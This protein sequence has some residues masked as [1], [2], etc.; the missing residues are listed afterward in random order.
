MFPRR[1][2]G[3]LYPAGVAGFDVQTTAYGR[4]AVDLLGRQ[5]RA[6]KR[7]DPLAPVT[8][9]VPSNYAAVSTRRALAGRRGGLAN[10]S[11]L[12]LHRLAERLG[13]A[14]LAAAGRRPVS[15]PVLAQAVRRVLSEAPGI[16]APV[17][18]H[19]ATEV[20]LVAAT[21]ELSGVT[22]PALQ[23]VAGCSP[24]AGDVVRIARRVRAD[25]APSWHDEHD[26]LEAADAA[27]AA[28]AQVGPLVVHLLQQLSPAGAQLLRTLSEHAPVRVNVGLSGD[29]DADRPV[30]EAHGR[31]GIVVEPP[32]RLERPCA[33]TV[34][35]VS[36]PDE[37]VRTAVRLVMGWLRDG[38][39]LGRVALLYGT[40][41]PYARLLNEQLTAAG[42]PHNGTPVRPIGDM[43]LG[44]TLRRLLSLADRDFRRPDVLAVVTGAPVLDGN[45]KAPSRAWERISRAAGVVD[46]DD[47]DRRLRVFADE[48]EHRADEADH[49]EREP[50]ARHLRRDA[51][52]ARQLSAFVRQLRSELD[53]FA[54][55]RSWEALVAG[56]HDLVDRYL[57]DDGYR[58]AWPEEE[59]Q[60][61]HRVEE[62]LDRLA[63]LDSV[64]APPPS[65]EVFRRTL[66]GELEV[67]LRRA[68]RFGHGVLVGHVSLAVGLEL[69]RVAVL[70]MAEGTFPVRRLE[71][72]LLPDR[73]RSAAGGE[74]ALRAERLQDDHR[75]LLAA[76]AAADQATLCFPRGDLRRRGDRAASRWLL[77]DAARLAGR[78]SLF[79]D[80]LA[81]LHGE[82]FEP[83]ASYAS[84][85]VG[86]VFPATAQELRLATMLRDP[87]AVVDEPGLS[88]GMALARAR[89]SE[90]FTRF[91]G[92]LGALDLPDYASS[93][94]VSATRLQAWAVCPH[95]FLMQY[96]LGV[97]VVEDPERSFEMSPLDKGRLVHEVL[98]RFVAEAM[99]AGRTT[100]WP[101]EDVRRLLEIAEEVCGAYESRGLTGRAL[102]WR[103]DRAGIVADLERFAREDTGHPVQVEWPFD[104]VPY[105]L[106]DGRSVFFR[107][108]VDRIDRAP[109]GSVTVVDYKT[110]GTDPYKGLSADDPHQGGRH[111]QLA[112][113]ATAAAQLLG[114]TDVT[115]EYWFVSAKGR[116]AR[117]GY[118]LTP[119]VHAAVGAAVASIVDGVRAGVFPARPPAEPSYVWVDCWYCSPD[120]LSTAEARRDW[121]RKRSDPSLEDYVAL[122]EPEALDEDG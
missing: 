49:E 34:V 51:E 110:G 5:V 101:D 25:L 43:L 52:R 61:A 76:V 44:R 78:P 41:D 95:A 111:L 96:L 29:A 69:D 16:F 85:L 91:D 121:E 62:A 6:D 77:A 79:T 50:L 87:E 118:P 72:S 100:P 107:G 102:F 64:E 90:G 80:D 17:A 31:A 1:V 27:L 114:V 82:W 89:R 3:V 120:G 119:E 103:R 56:A 2:T 74:L 106:P 40:A 53:G 86:C 66:E 33:T 117:L 13:A 23:A 18:H 75:H 39:A 115:A 92:N 67:A 48:Q 109:D 99:A 20:A 38:V 94:V 30:V 42:F 63:G 8:V 19:P 47:W 113:Y 24:R 83:V 59:Q 12:T 104:G 45:G 55:K 7:G 22:G 73:E 108:A 97:E 4:P 36:D 88:V 26:L 32:P 11:F 122:C 21:R 84:G 57:G 93:G 35:S 71:D 112:V 54:S 28:G 37:E 81:S 10:V 68:G 46:G 9:I 116:F 14:S 65:V 98:E 15:A 60:A 70:G 105:P 58:G